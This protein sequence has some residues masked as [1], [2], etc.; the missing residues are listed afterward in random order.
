[1]DRVEELYNEVIEHFAEI[2]GLCYKQM[3]YYEKLKAKAIKDKN[4]CIGRKD[5]KKEVKINI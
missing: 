2:R 1:M 4:D 5:V 3:K